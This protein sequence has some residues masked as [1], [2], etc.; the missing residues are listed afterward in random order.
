MADNNLMLSQL[1]SVLMKKIIVPTGFH[2]QCLVIK[3]MLRDDVCGIVDSLTD[4]LVQ[5][6]S[7]DFSIETQ[8]EKLNELFQDWLDGINK[9]YSGL[10]PRSINELAKEYYKERW[11][12]SSFPILK[13]S[14]WDKVKGT[15]LIMPTKMYFVDG[16]Q[17]KAKDKYETNDLTL[18]SYEY[19]IGS[20]E[21]DAVYL[22]KNVVISRP[23]CRWFDKYPVPYLIKRGVFHNWK[24]YQSLKS[25]E[26]EI[27]DQIIPYLLL[28]KKG[29]AD[30]FRDS[31]KSYSQADLSQIVLDFQELLSDYKNTAIGDKNVKTPTRAVNFDETIEQLIPDLKTIFD[32]I[33]FEQAERNILSGLGFIDVIQGV[34]STRKESVLNPAAF[35]Q[36]LN[37]GVD[38]FKAIIKQLTFLIKEK[39]DSHIKYNSN[40]LYVCNSPIT[41]FQT[42]EFKNQM[43]LLWE[44]G[45]ISTRTYVELV[46][47]V[48]FDTEIYRREKE[49]KLGLDVTMYPHITVN[50]EEKGIDVPGEKKNK[51]TDKNGKP[52]PQDKI[53]D[54]K[55]Y[56]IGS[57]EEQAEAT[58]KKCNAKFN[59]DETKEAGMGWAKCPKCGA[60]C[61]QADI[62]QVEA[63]SSVLEPTT[64]PIKIEATPPDVKEKGFIE[65]VKDLF[66]KE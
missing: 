40:N 56:K 9:D 22:N 33:L 7:V 6:A 15:N 14:K 25:K 20:S 37:A 23:Y 60:P 38:G 32:P 54:K 2:D 21:K 62:A 12:G 1:M 30:L 4:F 45:G 8:N 28:I 18:D 57:I 66:K 11:K 27:L 50:T 65:K 34:S 51:D 35:M 31:Q 55:K 42:D 49:N 61:T 5:S 52:I 29:S 10:V 59:F 16:G 58:C 41:A 44:R 3:E 48:S 64:A 63:V 53:T 47:N 19:Y 36:E 17:I 39:N 13:I 24:I 26:T 46:G 43:R